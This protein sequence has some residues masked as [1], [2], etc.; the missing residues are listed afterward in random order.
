[1][2]A[3][4]NAAADSLLERLARSPLLDGLGITRWGMDENLDP[5]TRKYWISEKVR[6][7]TDYSTSWTERRV[8]TRRIRRETAVHVATTMTAVAQFAKKSD[9]DDNAMSFSLVVFDEAGCAT[10]PNSLGV[11]QL[12]ASQFVLIGDHQQLPP[13]VTSRTAVGVGYQRSTFQRLIER[14]SYLIFL[15]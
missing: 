1:M 3:P 10:E 9:A 12:L 6:L 11:L 2:V 13:L 4:T 14:G 8:A 7:A 5:R 15:K